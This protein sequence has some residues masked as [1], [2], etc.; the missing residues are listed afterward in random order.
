MPTHATVREGRLSFPLSSNGVVFFF[1]YGIDESVDTVLRLLLENGADVD[2][3]CDGDTALHIACGRI[4]E[5]HDSIEDLIFDL[6][7]EGASPNARNSHGDTPLL[8]YVRTRYASVDSVAVFLAKGADLD[9][10]NDDGTTCLHVACDWDR[11]RSDMTLF[12][13]EAGANPNR[14]SRAYNGMTPFHICMSEKQDDDDDDD[15]KVAKLFLTHAQGADAHVTDNDGNTPLHY[16]IWSWLPEIV[17]SLLDLGADVNTV[18]KHGENAFTMKM[19]SIVYEDYCTRD[20]DELVILALLLPG[21]NAHLVSELLLRHASFHSNVEAVRTLLATDRDANTE[22]NGSETDMI[23]ADLLDEAEAT[24]GCDDF[25]CYAQESALMHAAHEGNGKVAQLLLGHRK[26]NGNALDGAL[27]QASERGHLQVVRALLSEPRCNINASDKDGKTALLHAASRGEVA[28]VRALLADHRCNLHIVDKYKKSALIYANECVHLE[29]VRDLL[30]DPRCNI[31]AV[32]DLLAC[33]IHAKARRE[34]HQMALKFASMDGHV[35]LVRF[36]MTQSDL[37]PAGLTMIHAAMGGHLEVV[38]LL[39]AS[40]CDVSSADPF[41][42]TALI[43]AIQG[44]NLEVVRLLVQRSH[45]GCNINAKDKTGKTALMH[46]INQGR[47]EL[48]RALLVDEQCNVNARWNVFGTRWGAGWTPLILAGSK[49]L[50]EVVQALL[51]DPRCDVNAVNYYGETALMR[52]SFEGRTSIVEQLLAANASM[53]AGESDGKTALIFASQHGR[54]EVVQCL[55]DKGANVNAHCQTHL[56]YTAL[57][58]ASQEGHVNIVRRILDAQSNTN[59]HSNFM[60]VPLHVACEFGHEGL[61]QLFLEAGANVN[62]RM[63]NGRTPLHRASLHGRVQV[64]HIL[65]EAQADAL[66]TEEMGHAPLYAAS[67]RGHFLAVKALLPHSSTQQVV[68]SLCLA[69][70]RASEQHF[71][72][73]VHVLLHEMVGRKASPFVAGGVR[74]NPEGIPALDRSACPGKI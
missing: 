45:H 18:N 63:P 22:G 27:I 13:L 23:H 34:T 48:V 3:D 55:L 1:F 54:G 43:R 49:H 59:A 19:N 52:F 57:S 65:L 12:L 35:E 61:V 39:L 41:G 40:G 4:C 47:V 29:L 31:N 15:E 72:N 60:A 74:S 16:A 66:A 32:R 6:L 14:Q 5:D 44:K 37:A 67:S 38:R 62:A 9:A 51:E 36:L 42:K 17:R 24:P 69:G 2:A 70:G 58:Y 68:S 20:D 46:A 30:S 7:K 21:S 33:Q 53:E 73:T 11:Q 64:I 56:G 25:Y 26:Y 28:I 50:V 8:C 10:A 71:R